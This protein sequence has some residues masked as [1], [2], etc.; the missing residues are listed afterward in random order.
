MTDKQDEQM[1][2][3][4]IRAVFEALKLSTE[5]KPIPL[6]TPPEPTLVFFTVAGNSPPLVS[7]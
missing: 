6:V 7:Q 1:N 4:E 3:D 5:P 2:D